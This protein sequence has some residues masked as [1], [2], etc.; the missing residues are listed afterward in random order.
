MLVCLSI[1]LLFVS[2]DGDGSG[3]G[4]SVVLVEGVKGGSCGV[5]G[6][7]VAVEESGGCAKWCWP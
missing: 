4:V 2:D 6:C 3:G 5:N 7:S 1:S